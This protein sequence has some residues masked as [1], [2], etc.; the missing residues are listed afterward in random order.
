[1]WWPWFLESVAVCRPIQIGKATIGC[2]VIEARRPYRCSGI[3]HG[4]TTRIAAGAYGPSRTVKINGNISVRARHP[5]TTSL[6]ILGQGDE[7]PNMRVSLPG[8]FKNV[9]RGLPNSER[10]YYE[11]CL[12]EVEKHLRET[13]RGEH[14]LQEFA[15]HYCLTDDTAPV[16]SADREV[17]K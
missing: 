13:I 2:D 17:S 1:M 6:R 3:R 14:T 11:Y 8:L 5:T 10:G 4:G 9:I 7:M 15:E 16:T 12:E